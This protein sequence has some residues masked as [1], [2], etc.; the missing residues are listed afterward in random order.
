[1]PGGYVAA[2]H[3]QHTT[4]GSAQPARAR[5][6]GRDPQPGSAP[7]NYTWVLEAD[8]QSCFDEIQHTALMDRLR[9]RIKD[10]RICTLVK[11]S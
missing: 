3:R 8:S 4:P 7:S 11:R 2:V 9:V 5:R 6:D 10:K 1:M